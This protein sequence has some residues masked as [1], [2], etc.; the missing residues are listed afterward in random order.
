MEILVVDD[1]PHVRMGMAISLREL[2]PDG[3]IIETDSL[4]GA[5]A[6]ILRHAQ[7]GLVLLD[8]SLADSGGVDTLRSLRAACE[9]VGRFPRIVIVSGNEDPGLIDSV[10]GEHGTGFIPKGVSGLIFKNA[11]Q[12]T[13]AGGVYIPELYL[14]ARQPRAL[15]GGAG[16]AGPPIQGEPAPPAC[17]KLTEMEQLVA[18][19]C[20][21]G[22]TYKHIARAISE[23]RG[24]DISDL[25]V[26]T[27][28]KN[29]AIKLG[30]LGEGKAAVV[31]QIGR[32][33]LRFP[34]R[35]AA[36]GP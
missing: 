21:Q 15:P 32:L 4:A 8:L 9:E 19:Y 18:S 34:V 14:R 1:H 13:L 23:V 17:R 20:V 12:L 30:I 10:L 3:V 2:V 6:A 27:H 11:V 28:V 35:Q 25:T 31:A 5:R 36:H 33:D 22:L 16:A 29:I 26:K 7:V 24:R